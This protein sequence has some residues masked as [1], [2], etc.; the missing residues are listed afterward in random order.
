MDSFGL[1]PYGDLDT[2]GGATM[3]EH[4][5]QAVDLVADG[6][7]RRDVGMALAAARRPDRVTLGRLAL[8]QA[9]IDSL[10]ET[11]TIDDA[12]S[13]EE[14]AQGYDDGGRWRGTVTRSLVADGFAEIVGMA[15]SRRPSRHRGY[16][17]R[18]RL[19]DRPAAVLYLKR[20]GTALTAYDATPPAGTG[21]AANSTSTSTTTAQG[22]QSN[23]TN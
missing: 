18:L 4:K 23:E 22:H 20:M 9:L 5:A 11:A 1:S 17:A 14:M 13:P 19:T 3:S 12:T 15:R 2:E 16:V 8:V 6:E 10:D 21:G 7:R